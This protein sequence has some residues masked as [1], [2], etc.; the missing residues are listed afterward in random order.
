MTNKS[1]RPPESIKTDTTETLVLVDWTNLMYRAWF[2]ANEKP[3]AAHCRFFDMLRL[4][5][6]KSKQPGVPLRVIFAGESRTK[7]Q[8]TK[9]MDAHLLAKNGK[10]DPK[11]RYKGTRSHTKN[12]DFDKFRSDLELTITDLGWKLLRVDGAE[13]DDVIASIVAQVCHRC[14]CKKKCENCDCAKKYTTD[15]VIFSGDR[16]LQQ[17][18]AW[19]RTLVYRAPGLFVNK[20]WFSEE[21]HIPVAKYA[22]YKA[23]I[24][25]KSD[26][27]RGVEGFGPVK[28][29]L[30]IEKDTVA[31]DIWELGDKKAVED[32]KMSLQLVN[33]DTKL[34]VPPDGYYTGPPIINEK[35]LKKL[36]DKRVIPEIRRMAVEF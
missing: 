28:A 2:A 29:Q 25:D 30:A 3:W 36:V 22:V 9:V 1:F 26:N 10:V 21:F 32:F 18:L 7:L 16:D 27:I 19:D 6:H 5:I 23:L 33:L 12:P 8:R 13:A 17:L 31:E 11:L 4:C 24:G 14:Y 34:D 20:D 35:T 15:A